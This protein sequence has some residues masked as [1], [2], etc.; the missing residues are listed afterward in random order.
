MSRFLL[1]PRA[2]KD[3]D[4]IWGYSVERWGEERTEIYV[5]GLWFGITTV[6]ADSRRG[7]SCD[8]I[9]PGYFKYAVGSHL[10]FYRLIPD[11]VD[12][13]RILHKRMDFERHL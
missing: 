11:G 10:L 7:Q 13:V 5:R 12:I 2:Q 6:A 9:R 1:S 8:D 4:E 3:L